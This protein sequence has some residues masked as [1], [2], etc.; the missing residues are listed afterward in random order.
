M[1]P[2]CM[3]NPEFRVF[4]LRIYLRNKEAMICNSPTPSPT[5]PFF[6]FLNTTTAKA[7]ATRPIFHDTPIKPIT[8]NPPSYDD[9]II[10]DDVIREQ[11]NSGG[12]ELARTLWTSYV[13][14]CCAALCL[15]GLQAMVV[16]FCL[17]GLFVSFV[18]T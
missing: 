8:P 6:L 10:L 7:Q 1:L 3:F 11:E 13:N 15:L 9:T 5:T 12:E 14:I 4:G 2:N 17:Q 16:R 18:R